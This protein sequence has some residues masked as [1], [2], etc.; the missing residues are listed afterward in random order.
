MKAN[1]LDPAELIELLG[2]AARAA[3]KAGAAEEAADIAQDT[4]AKLDDQDL[5][6][7]ANL[8]AWVQRVAKNAALDLQRRAK[9]IEGPYDDDLGLEPQSFSTKLVAKQKIHDLVEGLPSKYRAVIELTYYKGLPAADVGEHLGYS[10][11]TV[12][13][14]LTEARSMLRPDITA[15][16]GYKR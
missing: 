9:H 3:N 1:D 5:D 15:P 8:E 16:P 6:E 7:I 12:H 13:K 2:L 4:I 10:T 11:A 14:M